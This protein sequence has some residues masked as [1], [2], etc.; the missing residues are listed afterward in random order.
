MILIGKKN[1]TFI[2]IHHP[3]IPNTHKEIFTFLFKN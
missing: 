1:D 3:R 2:N